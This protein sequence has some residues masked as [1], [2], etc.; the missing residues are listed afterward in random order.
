[1]ISSTRPGRSRRR[2]DWTNFKLKFTKSEKII[3]RY[4]MSITKN[5]TTFGNKNNTL[6]S[7]SGRPE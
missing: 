2:L 3:K 4:G 5:K 6:I 1:M 7:L